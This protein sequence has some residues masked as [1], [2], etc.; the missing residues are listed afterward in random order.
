MD[1]GVL[2][3]YPQLRLAVIAQFFYVGAQVATW[4]NFI[5]YMKTYTTEPEKAC[6]YFLDGQPGGAGSGDDSS[7]WR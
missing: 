2:A 7:P 5:L 3:R 4:S 1:F 6:G